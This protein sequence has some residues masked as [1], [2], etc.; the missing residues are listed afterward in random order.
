[1]V[2]YSRENRFPFYRGDK[3]SV[4][5]FF[6][7]HED[8]QELD[9]IYDKIV[10]RYPALRAEGFYC[11]IQEIQNMKSDDKVTWLKDACDKLLKNIRAFLSD[12]AF[13]HH[14]HD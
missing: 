5:L 13:I 11:R 2:E 1:M 14:L 8:K 4:S 12:E 9:F 6:D 7:N 10:E 3:S